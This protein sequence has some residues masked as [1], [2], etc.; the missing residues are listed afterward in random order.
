VPTGD[1]DQKWNSRFWS[2]PKTRLTQTFMCGP[3]TLL[4][5]QFTKP[6]RRSKNPLLQLPGKIAFIT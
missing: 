2:F 6:Y 1:F 5:G 3:D 4:F